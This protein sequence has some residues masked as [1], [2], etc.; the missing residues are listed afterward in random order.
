MSTN[1]PSDPEIDI[2][3]LRGWIGREQQDTDHIDA[4]HAGLV[5]ATLG[6]EPERART[7]QALPP[8]WHWTWFL[9][10]AAPAGLGPD[11]HPARGGFLPPVPL[12]NR[13]WAG[14]DVEF[15]APVPIGAEITKTSRIESVEHKRGRSGDLV[16]VTVRHLLH[17][18][19]HLLVRE[20]QNIVYK[21]ANPPPAEGAAA[22]A[23][24]ADAGRPAASGQTATSPSGGPAPAPGTAA[25]LPSGQ[26]PEPPV[27]GAHEARFVPTSTML[28]RYSA[29]TFNGH[30]I[31]YDQDYCRE[32][33]GYP[34]LVIHGPLN[35]TMLAAH[36]ERASGRR[37]ARFT[38][39]GVAPAILGTAIRLR[40]T[41][42]AQAN[43]P[44]SVDA[45]RD[46]GEACMRAQAQFG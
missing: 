15:L 30:R 20:A 43:Q 10:A 1:T 2:E 36:A 3:H 31:H 9:E 44:W 42:G 28:F 40:A 24:P 32:I 17:Q 5:A 6:V 41:P 23:S 4:R 12:P 38:Y 33:E 21:P 27:P 25:Y 7:G 45:L 8:L 22:S 18:G 34:N 11:G 46:D 19:E 37:L 39:R 14:G 29:L 13:M 35:A 16:F 26:L